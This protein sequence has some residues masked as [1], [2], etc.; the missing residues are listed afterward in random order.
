MKIFKVCNLIFFTLLGVCIGGMIYGNIITEKTP[1]H[2]S[3]VPGSSGEVKCTT[4][5]CAVK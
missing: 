1:Q 5:S 3:T 4:T 2:T